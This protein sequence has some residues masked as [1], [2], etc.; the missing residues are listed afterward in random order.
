MVRRITS[1]KVKKTPG[2]YWVKGG[3]K[4]LKIVGKKRAMSIVNARKRLRIKK[5]R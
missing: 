1:S 3:G 4:T 5:R 2:F